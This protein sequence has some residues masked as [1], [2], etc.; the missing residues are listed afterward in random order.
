MLLFDE[1]HP[2]DFSGIVVERT[3]N[4][5]DKLIGSW[6]MLVGLAL[7]VFLVLFV[8]ASDLSGSIVLQVAAVLFCTGTAF[9]WIGYRWVRPKLRTD[10]LPSRDHQDRYFPILFKLR[11]VVKYAAVIGVALTAAHVAGLP[12]TESWIPASGLLVLIWSPL[13]IE[14]FTSRILHPLVHEKGLFPEDT[15]SRWSTPTRII[16][17]VMLRILWPSYVVFL[18]LNLGPVRPWFPWA[19]HTYIQ[20]VGWCIISLV[21]TSQVLVLHL[22]WM[23]E[24]KRDH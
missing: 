12:F 20:F 15:V 11:G 16:L 9:V 21:Y 18:I 10:D 1:L 4:L 14:R 3:V 17:S 5:F 22:G 7:W 6:L 8:S 24:L 2:M 13:L 23:R 19:Q